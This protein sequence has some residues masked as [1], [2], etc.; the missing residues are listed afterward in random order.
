M[1]YRIIRHNTDGDDYTALHEVTLDEEGIV[2]DW[3]EEMAV[4][5]ADVDDGP[6]A[7]AEMLAAAMRDAQAYPPLLLS[8]LLKSV[9]VAP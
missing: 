6:E 4:F 7:V 9:L 3:M 2:V 1:P 8:E 5:M